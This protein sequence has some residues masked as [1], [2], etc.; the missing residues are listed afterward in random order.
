[1]KP[2]TSRGSP[3]V[4]P[5]DRGSDSS[6]SQLHWDKLE[7]ERERERVRMREGD[8]QRERVRQE[9]RQMEVRQGPGEDARW[10]WGAPERQQSW[11]AS[12]E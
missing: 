3:N 12:Y 11:K 4:S 1:M 2:V 10:G 5:G 8:N 6:H 9:E 7:R